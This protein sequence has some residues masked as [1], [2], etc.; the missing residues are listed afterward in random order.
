MDYS[1]SRRFIDNARQYGNVLGLDNMKEL[2][3]RLSHPEHGLSF[4]HVTGTNGK[5]SV[6]AYL[7]SVLTE[8]GYRIGRYTSPAI[9]SYRERWEIDG[10]QISREG[11][12]RCMT[13][14]KQAVDEMLQEG[15]PH[16]TVFEIE[17][18]AALVYF[19]Q[20]GCSLVL[21]EVGMGGDLDATNIVR[22]TKLAVFTP[23]SLDHMEYLG[24]SVTEIARKK[25]GIIK[26]GCRVLT[27]MQE[28]EVMKVIKEK[29]ETV[30]GNAGSTV[31]SIS[32]TSGAVLTEDNLSGVSFRY[33]NETYHTP[34]AGLMQFQNAVAALDAL[35]ILQEIGYPTTVR[36]RKRGLS[37]TV[38]NG[39]FTVL[40][41]KPLFI[42]D[43]AHNPQAA[44]CLAQNMERYLSGKQIYFIIGM[45]KDKDYQEVLRITAPYAKK[46][47]TIQ[48]PDN[49][50]A[51]PAKKLAKAAEEVHSDV[52]AYE[53]IFS[54]IKRARQLA[55][56]EDAIL[57][58]G[59]LSFL[60]E[61][62]ALYK[63]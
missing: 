41:D 29:C 16:P 12:A 51:L 56:E 32:D 3:A 24:S 59:S 48:T 43:G 9:F 20:Y 62:T 36:Q 49:A 37:Q 28:E 30:L 44:R 2:M 17:T 23:I 34:L 39:R 5:G 45:F 47:L 19:S 8:A 21:W 55:G 57:V 14:V 60:G 63:G 10:K 54:A 40:G 27:V 61:V 33:R 15:L 58:F 7:Y 52:E 22:T 53:E 38:W 6:I 18:A 35:E 50:R 42:I 1:Q 46:I 13:T 25:A 31:L 26:P 11:F 4:I